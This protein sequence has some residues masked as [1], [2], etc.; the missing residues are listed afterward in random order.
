MN[1][2]PPVF[3]IEVPIVIGIGSLVLALALVLGPVFRPFFGRRPEVL[4][5]DHDQEPDQ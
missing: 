5:A 3:G 1:Y 4:A 2:A